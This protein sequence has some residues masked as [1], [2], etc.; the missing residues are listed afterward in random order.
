MK[1]A[2]ALVLAILLLACAGCAIDSDAPAKP[3]QPNRS[4]YTVDTHPEG[5]MLYPVLSKAVPFNSRG[6]WAYYPDMGYAANSFKLVNE[7]WEDVTG[8]INGSFEYV[9]VDDAVY[10][11][12]IRQY[13]LGEPYEY[14]GVRY[15][16]GLQGDP[17]LLGLDGKPIPAFDGLIAQKPHYC[18]ATL[19]E[20]LLYVTTVEAYNTA[21]EIEWGMWPDVGIFN[22]KTGKLQIPVE[23]TQLILL[24]DVALGVKDGV[25]YKLDY[26]GKVLA[27]LGEDWWISD[28]YDGDDLLRVNDITYI[29]RGGEVALELSGVRGAS[30][31]RGEYAWG[32]LGEPG[33]DYAD[34]VFIDRQGRRVGGKTYLGINSWYEDYYVANSEASSEVLDLSLQTVFSS[35]AGGVND[36]VDDRIIFGVWDEELTTTTTT[37]FD[38][39]SGDELFSIEGYPWND[40]GFFTV[41]DN[42]LYTLY[43]LDGKLI[44]DGAR[45]TKTA[46]DGRFVYVDNGKH[47][48]YIDAK[49]DWVYR[50]N[51]A[52]F[53][54]ED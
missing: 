2:L 16:I 48:G 20:G 18:F 52:Y 49:G 23:Y 27:T 19:P 31:F 53:N 12:Q 15:T 7:Q 44:F 34:C 40:N 10:G 50:I 3:G 14:E 54:L 41:G 21:A 51:A 45:V 36:I 46:G 35:S 11:I 33:D 1:Q 42:S 28:F 32:W 37:V 6:G 13:E 30:N 26:E 22:T 29:D 25:M 38:I 8:Y 17:Y 39:R 43:N 9:Y 47:M 4:V 24:E 5:P